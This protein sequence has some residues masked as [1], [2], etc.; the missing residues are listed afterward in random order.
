MENI[1]ELSFEAVPT[2]EDK[3]EAQVKEKVESVPTFEPVPTLELTKPEEKPVPEAGPDYSI[4]TA[5]EQ[6]VVHE[7]AQKIDITNPNLSTE[8]GAGAQ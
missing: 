7:F 8:Y 6:K 3:T 1:P 2:M 5:E 4:L